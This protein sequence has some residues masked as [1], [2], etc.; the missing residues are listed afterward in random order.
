MTEIRIFLPDIIR[1]LSE[2]SQI[3]GDGAYSLIIFHF[4]DNHNFCLQEL[5]NVEDAGED[6]H[7]DNICKY[8]GSYTVANS[9]FTVVKWM[10]HSNISNNKR[11]LLKGK[12]N[13]GFRQ[14]RHF[15]YC[16]A[17]FWQIIQLKFY[18][19]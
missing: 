7:R 14:R 4:C 10:T 15:I 5:W 6:N 3:I 16:F 8:P 11:D 17:M 1:I 9:R 13:K 18:K 19:I 2:V 12:I